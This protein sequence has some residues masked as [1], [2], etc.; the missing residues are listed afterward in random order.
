MQLAASVFVRDLFEPLHGYE[1]SLRKVALRVEAAGVRV[2]EGSSLI[3][4]ATAAKGNACAAVKG[5]H[6]RFRRLRASQKANCVDRRSYS[7]PT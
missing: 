2:T 7:W 5:R 1:P 3:A 6:S 4:P